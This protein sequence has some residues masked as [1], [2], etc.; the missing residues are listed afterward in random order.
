M[1][2]HTKK[3]SIPVLK[4]IQR[5]I[6]YIRKAVKPVSLLQRLKKWIKK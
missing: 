3:N 1:G 5:D 2:S 4:D 6:K